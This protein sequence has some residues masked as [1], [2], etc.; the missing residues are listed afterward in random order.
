M[1]SYQHLNVN[2]LELETIDKKLF[3]MFSTLSTFDV[4]NFLI[5]NNIH[6]VTQV[7]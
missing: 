7:T 1:K 2:N 6:N 5:K 3:T 4:D